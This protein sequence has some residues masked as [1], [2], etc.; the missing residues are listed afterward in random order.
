MHSPTTGD[1]PPEA[2]PPRHV[3]VVGGLDAGR[4]IDLPVL[5]STVVVGR[6]PGHAVHLAHPTVSR[7]HATLEVAADAVKLTD[8]GSRNGT[9]LEGRR[10]L[11]S[12]PIAPGAVVELGA[13][14]L[15]LRDGPAPLPRRA[16]TAPNPPS[17]LFN[18]PPRS[19]RPAPPPALELPADRPGHPRGAGGLSIAVLLGPVAF[20]AVTAVLFSPLMA[21]LA[22]MGPTV[23]IGSWLE[24]RWRDRRRHHRSAGVRRLSLAAFELEARAR[25]SA[26]LQSRR[27]AHPD[28]ATLRRWADGGSRLW[29]RRAD[30][31][32]AFEVSLGLAHQVW[33]PWPPPT[34]PIP[35]GIQSMLDA[36]GP[37]PD[38][39][40]VA[41]LGPGRAI[42]VVGPRLARDA[43]LRA[44]VC[45]MA[46]LH[47]PCDLSVRTLTAGP[48]RAAGRPGPSHD[49]D[50]GED[51]WSF[52]SRLPH[53]HHPAGADTDS[54][55][56]LDLVVVPDA[57]AADLIEVLAGLLRPEQPAERRSALVGAD[58]IEQLPS[59]CSTVVEL[60]DDHGRADV[61]TPGTGAVL[62]HVLATGISVA[63]AEAWG[64][65][66][67][68]QRDPEVAS[69]SGALPDRV[70]TA[71]LV[72]P[73]TTAAVVERWRRARCTPAAVRAPVGAVP[74]RGAT[75]EPFTLDLVADGPH[76]L[77]GGTTGSGK[78]EL[79]RTLVLS[80]A[81]HHPPDAVSFLLVDY[82]GGSA[83]DACADLPHTVGLV[84]DLDQHLATRALVSLDA[85]IRRREQ[86]LRRAGVA[87][88]ANGPVPSLARLVVVIDEF[89]TLAAELP[90][91][92]DAL[93]DVA[94]RGRS[95]GVHLVLATQRPHGAVND[96]IRT[97]TNLRIAL[98]ML[99]RAESTDV[100]DDPAAARLPRDR[101]GRAVARLGHDELVPFQAALTEPEQL[102]SLVERITEAAAESGVPS[103]DTPWLPPL[104]TTVELDALDGPDE[105]DSGDATTIRRETARAPARATAPEP[106]AWCCRWR[107]PTSPPVSAN[108][109][110]PG[111]SGVATCS[112]SAC[113]AVGRPRLSSPWRSPS[114]IGSH[115]PTVTS[116]ASPTAPPG[117]G[118]SAACPMSE[119]SSMPTTGDDRPDS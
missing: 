103:P 31:P 22:L 67:G 61:R 78:S 10:V 89:A 64:A 106:T 88:L 52:A 92:L 30:H 21:V 20:A 99:D 23:M 6:D 82:K 33:W 1:D 116:T 43:V 24:R 39:P 41:R 44:L 13:V 107:W 91:F 45:Q 98:R 100:V 83:F 60:I 94:Q 73:T 9:R 86:I 5:Q 75:V 90:G 36:I 68:R 112:S 34:A 80:L 108:G 32:D 4:T 71:E 95:L 7:H 25:H 109:R 26:E 105:A 50:D 57:A 37:M 117:W 38:A 63:I 84:T 51:E 115:R 96:R 11:P 49:A 114:P 76:A 93:V 118:C 65:S 17:R 18:R 70:T 56:P 35:A 119:R 55:S 3:A 81:L 77:I 79:L 104:P 111:T 58:A 14:A 102:R 27:L 15:D 2:A 66:L 113:P 85:E 40:V 59:W 110:G 97:N 8:I 74:G 42:G 62:H 12:T 87:D 72:G 69:G 16:P 48:L 19:A 101:P 46:T 29:E 47:G 28:P 54:P 53:A